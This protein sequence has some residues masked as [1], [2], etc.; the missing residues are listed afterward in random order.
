MIYETLLKYI[1]V[2]LDSKL[3][4]IQGTYI[5]IME[6]CFLCILL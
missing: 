5:K 2:D 3:Y 4:K 6:V 1:F